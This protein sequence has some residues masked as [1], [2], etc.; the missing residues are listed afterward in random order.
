MGRLTSIYK[1][2]LVHV[3]A[4]IFFFKFEFFKLPIDRQLQLIGPS[5]VRAL[6]GLRC[7]RKW[8]L[9]MALFDFFL[10]LLSLLLFAQKGLS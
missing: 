8:P 10:L 1:S 9:L 3:H 2:G 5:E 7:K 4:L 6:P